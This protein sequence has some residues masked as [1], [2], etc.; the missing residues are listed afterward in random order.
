VALRAAGRGAENLA[1]LERPMTALMRPAIERGREACRVIWKKVPV[2]LA[3]NSAKLVC[4][5]LAIFVEEP[6]RRIRR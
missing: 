6:V 3:V 4:S 2:L 1:R 5:A